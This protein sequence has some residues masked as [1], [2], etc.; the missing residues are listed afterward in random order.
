LLVIFRTADDLSAAECLLKKRTK[1]AIV[2]L[3]QA[4]PDRI[5]PSDVVYVRTADEFRTW[6]RS[7]GR[8]TEPAKFLLALETEFDTHRRVMAA[9]DSM[10]VGLWD[11]LSSGQDQ[12]AVLDREQR[13]VAVFGHWS[14]EP[15]R[16]QTDLL[17]KRTRDLFGSDAAAVHEAAAF[18]ALNG[19]HTAYEWSITGMPRRAHLFT[20][21]S[22]LRSDDGFVAGVVLA[23]RNITTLKQALFEAKRSLQEKTNQLLDVERGMRQIADT[24][25]RSPRSNARQ[26]P[27]SGL[28]TSA[29]LSGREQEV[30]NLLRRGTRLRSI[31]QTLGISIETV[32]RHVKSMFR[33]TGVHSQEALVKL[34]YDTSEQS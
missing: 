19:E 30:V 29:F 12:I 22:P 15:P 16:S 33:K 25:Q 11:V 13:I 14:K 26:S 18:R 8:R 10:G 34:F 6:L 24:L 4:L 1:A 21:A 32:R 7:S 31:A 5:D 28:H 23:T 27:A 20:T 3:R 2:R 9:L 17:G